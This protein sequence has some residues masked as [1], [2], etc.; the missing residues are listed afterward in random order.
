MPDQPGPEPLVPDRTDPFPQWSFSLRVVALVFF[1][2]ACILAV[3]VFAPL[4]QIL[5]VSFL[6]AYFVYIPSRA[7]AQSRYFTHTSS[8]LLVYL[9]LIGIVLLVALLLLPQALQLINATVAGAQDAYQMLLASLED[10]E[11]ADGVVSI[12]GLTVDL[13]PLILPVREALLREG[14]PLD[15]STA[16]PSDIIISV[17]LTTIAD[18]LVDFAEV[19]V[20]LLTVFAVSFVQFVGNFVIALIISAFLLVDV[21]SGRGVVARSIPPL[22]GREITILFTKLDVAWMGFLRGQVLVGALLGLISLVQ[23]VLMGVPYAPILAVLN[24]VISLIPNI[25]GLL[26][27]IPVAIVTLFLGSTVF[28]DMSNV[29]FTILVQVV[30][31]LYS[32][33]IYSVVAP[34]IVGKSVSLPTVLVIV[35]LFLGFL[36]GGILGAFVVVPVMASLSV[37]MHYLLAKI[38]DREP[39]PGQPMPSP[40]HIGFFGQLVFE[41]EPGDTAAPPE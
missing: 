37:F 35:G 29:S 28:T 5:F 38:N 21:H 22:Y 11:T 39:F 7:I 3:V 15:P 31:L 12:F 17:S 30:M 4:T 26:S 9:I 32:Q 2:L 8:V 36:I 24:G 6:I 16:P 1:I 33:V 34:R 25:G 20:N 27:M 13:N 41:E 23:F 40:E 10:Y 14:A 19:L 18:F